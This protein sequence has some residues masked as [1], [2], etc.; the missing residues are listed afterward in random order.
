MRE[1]LALEVAMTSSMGVLAVLGV[2]EWIG[3][4]RLVMKA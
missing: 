3:S 1:R 4:A 2:D